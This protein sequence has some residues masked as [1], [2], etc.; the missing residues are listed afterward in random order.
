MKY[1]FFRFNPISS[2]NLNTSHSSLNILFH[3]VLPELIFPGDRCDLYWV[4]LK[5]ISFSTY[6]VRQ[7]P[8]QDLR[9]ANASPVFTV[10]AAYPYQLQLGREDPQ[11]KRHRKI[12]LQYLTRILAI[13]FSLCISCS[14]T[15]SRRQKRERNPP[16]LRR[17]S[18]HNGSNS[19]PFYI[20]LLCHSLW[21]PRQ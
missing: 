3:L 12:L 10:S 17:Q 11:V 4:L 8:S 20:S 13:T 5:G 19:S 16:R 7:F 14:L 15:P 21:F 1:T 9:P 18:S 6:K 2:S